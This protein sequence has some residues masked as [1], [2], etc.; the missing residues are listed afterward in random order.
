MKYRSVKLRK[1]F[2]KFYRSCQEAEGGFKS[3]TRGVDALWKEENFLPKGEFSWGG[4]RGQSK[5]GN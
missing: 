3:F 4:V 1:G 2:T 5:P